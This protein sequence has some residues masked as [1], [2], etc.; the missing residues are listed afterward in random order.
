MII[1]LKLKFF[2]SPNQVWLAAWEIDNF[3]WEK[4]K[5]KINVF[6][7]NT[8]NVYRNKENLDYNL[9]NKGENITFDLSGKPYLFYEL[10]NIFNDY[11]L[12]LKI[13]PILE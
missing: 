7:N 6:L 5:K 10:Q 1:E 3:L 12:S 9:Q 13:K 11:L 2:K 4:E 8:L